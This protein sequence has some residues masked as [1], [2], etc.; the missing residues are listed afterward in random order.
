M[1][2]A[3]LSVPAASQ[4][5]FDRD[6]KIFLV[7]FSHIDV[8]FTDT[9]PVVLDQHHDYLDTVLSFMSRQTG[10]DEEI[11]FRWTIE[12][13]WI[14]ESYIQNRPPDRIDELMSRISS[15]EIELGAMH[16]GLQTDLCGPEELIRSLYYTQ[17][18]SEE[19]NIPVTTAIINDTPGFTWS[20]AQILAKSDIPYLSVAMNSVLS[21]FF[22]TTSLPY[23]FYWEAQSGNKTLVWRSIDKS[24]AYLEGGITFSVYGSYS[25]MAQRLTELLIELQD[26][27]Y[28]YDAVLINCATG[29]NGPPKF[30]IL[31]NAGLWNQSHE[32]TEIIVSTF[33]DFF[34]YME[35]KYSIEIPVYRGDAPNWWSWLFAISASEGFETSRRVQRKLPYAET[36]A[37]IADATRGSFMYPASKIRRAY[38]DNLL[39][40]DHNMGALTD[41]GNIEFWTRKMDWIQSAEQAAD[42][43]LTDAIGS[44]ST[45]IGHP[46]YTSIAVYNGTGRQR[47]DYVMI[48]LNDHTIPDVAGYTLIDGTS[49]FE[50]ETQITFDN[51]FVMWVNDVPAFGYKIFYF[52]PGGSSVLQHNELSGSVI[53]NEFYRLTIDGQSGS[54]SG[55]YDK[56]SATELTREDGRFNRFLYNSTFPPTAMDVIGS[57]S[58]SVFQRI[59]LRGEAQ[60][61]AGYGTE[62]IMSND[63]K[64][65]DFLNTYDKLPPASFEAIDFIFDLGLNDAR[66]EYEIPLG[67]VQ[68]FED[69]LS[70]FRS[71]HYAMQRW[72]IVSSASAPERVAIATDAVAVHGYQSGIFN[73]AVRL[74]ASFNTSA[75]AYRAGVGDHTASFAVTSGGT[76][77]DAAAA[78]EF[79]YNFNNPFIPVILPAIG[80]T[81][82]PDASFSFVTIEPSGMQVS[83][84]K[85]AED[86]YGYIIRLYNPLSEYVDV[87]LEF[88]TDVLGA[89][90]T[91]PVEVNRNSVPVSDNRITLS[92]DSFGITTLRVLIQKPVSVDTG[93][94]L[95]SSYSLYQNYPNPFNAST[96]IRYRL[97]EHATVRVSV[98]N[99]LGQKV[100]ALVAGEKQAG[101]HETIWYGTALRGTPVPSGMYFYIFQV[102][103]GGRTVHREI[104]TMTIVK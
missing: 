1:M 15:G 99:I 9:V 59:V 29:D 80:N 14:L 31:N 10:L 69:E 87:T 88:G 25:V 102:E 70:G 46:E 63:L 62:I 44:L 39:Y 101:E 4:P 85:K 23:A 56:E 8:G 93:R 17:E 84:I 61:T 49:N 26:I 40:E 28:P 73:G 91:S 50:V 11:P 72:M 65:I 47:S 41:A 64:R 67:S 5:G 74:I 81:D 100:T 78:G 34:S 89:Y 83:T 98:Y 12:I 42:D 94:V 76:S 90:E 97:P 79:A 33:S 45:E 19:Y 16:F 35:K 24:W 13:P 104:K 71:N 20:L 57:D 7:P 68:L 38:I 95:S 60:G 77:L 82:Y 58:G 3:F 96:V 32:Q 37:A 92:L 103:V 75:S 6:W 55:L 48:D 51:Q 53:E 66:L 36:A 86:G 22:E 52:V 30:E 27:G 2:L 54:V 43:V 18:L 21:E